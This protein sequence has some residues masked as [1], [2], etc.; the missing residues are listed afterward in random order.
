MMLRLVLVGMVAALGVTIPGGTNRGGWLV[1]AERW[2]NS[3]L[4]DWDTWTPDN[5]TG[6]ARQVTATRHECEQCRLARAA[7]AIRERGAA[8]SRVADSTK[9]TPVRT[10]AGSEK[11]IVESHHVLPADKLPAR[12]IAFEPIDVSD[13]FYAGVAF[14]LNRNAEGINLAESPS[15]PSATFAR[16]QPVAVAEALEAE[17][18]PVLCG[19]TDE[20]AIDWAPLAVASL[21]REENEPN[22]SGTFIST[23]T[24]DNVDSEDTEAIVTAESVAPPVVAASAPAPA[25]TSFLELSEVFACQA[26]PIAEDDA[27]AY[28]E[29]PGL[30]VAAVTST[31]SVVTQPAA[32]LNPAA[33][34]VVAEITSQ[35]PDRAAGIPWPVFAPV[36]AITGPPTRVVQETTVPWPV[37]APLDPT[38]GANSAAASISSAATPRRSSSA[39]AELGQAV[40]LT[41]QAMYAW[42]GL[43]V[44]SA[45]LEVTAR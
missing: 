24:G 43:L 20:D 6:Q 22:A 3:V 38:A 23:E 35:T 9:S 17:L 26:G 14:E 5:R 13:D 41:R 16:T 4:V 32:P 29:A 45:P 12:K 18:P 27:P 28:D 25:P 15:A 44:G 36:G 31:A 8:P 40:Q 39:A 42:M 19:M 37:F 7:I 30:P 2:S 34:R 33:T 11:P 10:G 21:L 1:S